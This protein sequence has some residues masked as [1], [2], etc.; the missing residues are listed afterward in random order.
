[1]RMIINSVINAWGKLLTGVKALKHRVHHWPHAHFLQV[2]HLW[3]KALT[4][5]PFGPPTDIANSCLH[6]QMHRK[7]PLGMDRP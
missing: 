2:G 5:P 3:L 7:E 6:R 1:M 4:L